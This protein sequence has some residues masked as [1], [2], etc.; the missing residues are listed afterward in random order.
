MISLL[1]LLRPKGEMLHDFSSPFIFV[2]A[3]LTGGVDSTSLKPLP[4][5]LARAVGRILLSHVQ[6]KLAD[7]DPLF[8]SSSFLSSL[9]PWN[10]AFHDEGQ[11]VIL[12]SS[13]FHLF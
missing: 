12:S 8:D 4:L 1:R 13:H 2:N 9:R 11:V 3:Q 7:E 5:H 10:I 6:E